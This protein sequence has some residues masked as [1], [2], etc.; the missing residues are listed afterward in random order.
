MTA[1]PEH[2]VDRHGNVWRV[3]RD[4]GMA[5]R[6]EFDRIVSIGIVALD[7]EAGPLLPFDAMAYRSAYPRAMS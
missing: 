7:A 6:A 4:G 5:T 1:A 3:V 2:V